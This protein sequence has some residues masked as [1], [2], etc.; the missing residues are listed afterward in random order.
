MYN[1]IHIRQIHSNPSCRRGRPTVFWSLLLFSKLNIIMGIC[2]ENKR[3]NYCHATKLNALWV[4]ISPVNKLLNPPDL[5]LDQ[6][7]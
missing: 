2:E 3:K 6:R 1:D 4:L 7:E 5:F